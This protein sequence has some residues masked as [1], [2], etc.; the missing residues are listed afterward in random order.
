[1]VRAS[2]RA[3]T[4]WMRASRRARRTIWRSA[5]ACGGRPG[6]FAFVGAAPQP[7]VAVGEVAQG[8]AVDPACGGA[9]RVPGSARLGADSGGFGADRVG[10]VVVAVALAVGGDDGSSLLPAE[11]GGRVFGEGPRAWGWVRAACTAT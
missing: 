7:Q 3:R 8:D 1:M 4:A 10:R 5:A 6:G 2:W 9:G 11:R